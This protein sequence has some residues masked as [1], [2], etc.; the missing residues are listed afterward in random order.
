[1]NRLI[2]FIAIFAVLTL[3]RFD[4]ASAKILKKIEGGYV[5]F[6]ANRW[7]DRDSARSSNIPEFDEMVRIPVVDEAWSDYWIRFADGWIPGWGGK[8]PGF[9]GGQGRAYGCNP[10]EP[11]GWSTR[12]MWNEG[13]RPPD[14]RGMRLY[15]Y[16]QDRDS[17]CGD[18][19][20]FNPR[21]PVEGRWHR[22]TQHVRV[23]TPGNKDAL[24]RQYVNGNLTLEVKNIALRGDVGQNVARIERFWINV[25]RGGASDNWAVPKDT[26]ID[27]KDFYV[28]DC[29]PDFSRTDP[30][31]TPRCVDE[32]VV[33]V[34]LR[35]PIAL[36]RMR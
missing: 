27:F 24:I 4:V 5:K 26:Q 7:G 20:P 10:E 16:K 30:D 29:Q 2:L 3:I 34:E 6:E 1:M 17:R 36:Y 22:I 12:L 21:F 19:T 31:E 8:L 33:A 11:D 32:P 28:L 9:R 13:W 25:F 23:N 15:L 18:S 14:E 35:A